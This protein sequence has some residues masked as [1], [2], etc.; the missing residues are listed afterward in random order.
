[1][2]VLAIYTINILHPG[3]LLK[4]GRWENLIEMPEFNLA[5]SVNN[6]YDRPSN[7]INDSHEQTVW[8]SLYERSPAHV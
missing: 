2:V 8:S 6:S 7:T 5:I 3:Y 1:M 4:E